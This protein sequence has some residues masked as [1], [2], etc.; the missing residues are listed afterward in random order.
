MGSKY[1]IKWFNYPW[2]GLWDGDYQTNNLVVFLYKLLK[3]IR[4]YDGINVEIR[5][6]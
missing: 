2:N 4:E 5:N 6:G 3:C 1:H